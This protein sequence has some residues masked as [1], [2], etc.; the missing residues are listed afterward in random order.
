MGQFFSIFCEEQSIHRSLILLL[1]MLIATLDRALSAGFTSGDEYLQL[2]RCHCDYMRRRVTT[3]TEGTSWKN[4]D[5]CLYHPLPPPH[6]G[7]HTLAHLCPIST[8]TEGTCWKMLNTLCAYL[9]RETSVFWLAKK[10][11]LLFTCH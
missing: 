4:P 2:W 11:A 1:T 8:L 7:L 6:I 5:A 9:Q 3:W 10:R